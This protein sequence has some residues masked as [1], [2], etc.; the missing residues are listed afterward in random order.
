MFAKA[1]LSR[2]LLTVPVFI[3]GIL[4]LSFVLALT[5]RA[6]LLTVSE[7]FES[8][9]GAGFAPSP[10][11][12]QLDSDTWS[13][14]GLSDG[15]LAFGDTG[16]SGDFARGSSSGGESTGGI[17]AFDTGSNVI[18]G[19]QPGGSDFTPGSFTLRMR[20]NSGSTVTSVDVAYD[21]FYYNDKE[22]ANSLNLSYSTDGTTFTA[23]SALDFTTPEAADSPSEPDWQSENK[24]TTIS[25]L[26]LADGDLFY[27]R[28][29]GDDESGSG[30]RDEYG[31]DNISVSVLDATAVN[32]S[33]AAVRGQVA[34]GGGVAAAV[35]LL[36]AITL[37]ALGRRRRSVSA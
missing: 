19:V 14:T 33:M 29:T 32:L 36:A 2:R 11:A 34:G 9:T 3:F 26:S 35:G 16:T 27:L 8:F 25:G 20:N 6:D 17:Y 37:L 15:A 13:V 5:A 18:L 23:V 12:G 10:T 21:I 22:R 28:W 24:S 7:D 30:A 4:L 1:A 31:I